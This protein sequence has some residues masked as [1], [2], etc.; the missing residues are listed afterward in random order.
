M[1]GSNL[2]P[3]AY[4]CVIIPESIVLVNKKLVDYVVY[5][6]LEQT[7]G[8]GGGGGGLVLLSV[9][10]PICIVFPRKPKIS[11]DLRSGF[12]HQTSS[13]YQMFSETVHLDRVVS[14]MH[15]FRP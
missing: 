8:S 9:D 12:T 7:I 2:D 11:G 1:Q 15:A 6:F 10:Q 3:A 4:K 14:K 5:F 13:K